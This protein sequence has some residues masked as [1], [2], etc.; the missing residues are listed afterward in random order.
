MLRR[1]RGIDQDN[2]VADDPAGLGYAA[3]V[4]A[5]SMANSYALWKILITWNALLAMY[6]IFFFLFF[7]FG[8]RGTSVFVWLFG[9]GV[10]VRHICTNAIFFFLIEGNVSMR[11]FVGQEWFYC[12]FFFLLT[13]R[14]LLEI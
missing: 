12:Y 2:P 8:Q 1:L 4:E 9:V 6:V 7:F 3:S 11:A 14:F 13:P 5:I 10:G